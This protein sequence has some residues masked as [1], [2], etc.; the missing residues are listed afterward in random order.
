MAIEMTELQERFDAEQAKGYRGATVDPNPNSAYS[1]E[2]DPMTSPRAPRHGSN[3]LHIDEFADPNHPDIDEIHGRAGLSDEDIEAAG[4]VTITDTI[5]AQ[6]DADTVQTTELDDVAPFDG[7]VEAA[8]FTP[9]ETITGDAT[10]NRVFTLRN[11]SKG[12]DLGAVT[13]VATK[14]ADVAAALTLDGTPTVSEGDELSVI[15]TV[16][17]T[18]VAHDGG[19]ISVTFQQTDTA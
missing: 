16:G 7:V 13:T 3:F 4:Q 9:A 6:A 18:G 2:T 19:T 15:E 10:N 11:V 12:E 17:G 8:S 1:Q 14:T 5:P